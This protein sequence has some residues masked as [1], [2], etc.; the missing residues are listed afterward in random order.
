MLSS[1]RR[2]H[3]K[4]CQAL[5]VDLSVSR[6][7]SSPTW[8]Q[9]SDIENGLAVQKGF[10]PEGMM[11][12]RCNWTGGSRPTEPHVS[13]AVELKPEVWMRRDDY[14]PLPGSRVNGNQQ[15]GNL[16]KLT[17]WPIEELQR[18]SNLNRPPSTPTPRR[19]S[20]ESDHSSAAARVIPLTRWPLSDPRGGRRAIFDTAIPRRMTAD[21]RYVPDPCTGRQ[22][23]DLKPTKIDH[24]RNSTEGRPLKT[25]LFSAD[26]TYWSEEDSI[27]VLRNDDGDYVGLKT[28]VCTPAKPDSSAALLQNIGASQHPPQDMA[29]SRANQRPLGV[30]ASIETHQRSSNCTDL[31]DQRFP[32]RDKACP[33]RE[34][35]KA[36][37]QG[38]RGSEKCARL[39][40][41]L[42]RRKRSKQHDNTI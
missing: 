14:S 33:S 36:C 37:L 27:C 42:C 13:T 34:E 35:H 28:N 32:M 5:T 7:I 40:S 3:S 41:R 8:N 20:L 39:M 26:D 15:S 29:L 11:K 24:D 30:T 31:L 2:P 4:P 12:G 6:T 1:S 19:S 23:P 21:N 16:I 10:H 38:K 17:Q 25:S 22:T 18:P 9:S